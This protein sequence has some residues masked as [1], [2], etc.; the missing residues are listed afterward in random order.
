MTA[1]AKKLE[2][3]SEKAGVQEKEIAAVAGTT[4]QTLHRWCNTKVTPQSDHLQRV[5]DL[6]YVADELAEIYAPDEVRI[7]L[8]ERHKL[9]GGRRPVELISGGETEKVLDVIAQ[10]K[11][12]AYV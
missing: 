10:L 7:W 4:P 9:L 5:L 6:A 11:D 8:F 3:I 1:L 2:T 12:G